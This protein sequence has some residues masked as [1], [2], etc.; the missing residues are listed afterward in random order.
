MKTSKLYTKCVAAVISAAM[1]ISSFTAVPAGAVMTSGIPGDFDSDGLITSNDALEVLRASV[2]LSSQDEISINDVDMDGDGSLTSNDAMLIL[3]ES[4]SAAKSTDDKP[5]PYVPKTDMNSV[6]SGINGFSSELFRRTYEQGQKS[7]LSGGANGATKD[8]IMNVLCSGSTFTP[9][10]LDSY[11]KEYMIEL[12]DDDYLNAANAVFCLQRDDIDFNADF[13][14]RAVNRYRSEI[15][16]DVPGDA[17]VGKINNWASEKTK[18]MIPKLLDKLN[19]ETIMVLLNALYFESNWTEEFE[20]LKPNDQNYDFE[21]KNYNGTIARP[22]LLRTKYGPEEGYYYS[23]SRCESFIKNYY[24]SYQ[25]IAILPDESIGIDKFVNELDSTAITKIA[26]CAGSSNLYISM[27]AFD[28]DFSYTMNDA[29]K[30]MGMPLSFDQKAADFSEL[31][32]SKFDDNIY[33]SDVIQKSKIQLTAKGTKAAA[34]TAITVDIENCVDIEMPLHSVKLDRPFVYV[35]YDRYRH[36]PVFIG[37][38]CDLK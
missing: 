22:E 9:E 11:M 2:G 38:I 36:L 1:L 6:E 18:G 25:F 8:E 16:S 19:S 12:E 14:Q 7:M 15:F 26:E 3:R 21:F 32:K 20:S 17:A 23:D 13:T 34:V 5:E 33:V 31:A 29:L 4:T 10:E 24:G 28:M 35:I 30:D 37:T 27:P